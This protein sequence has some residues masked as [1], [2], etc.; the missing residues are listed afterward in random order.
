[1]HAAWAHAGVY[2]PHFTG[3]ETTSGTPTTQG[4]L[5]PGDLVLVPGSRGNVVTPR[6]VGMYIGHG[7]VVHA[8][9]AGDV[10]RVEP[11]RDF[12]AHG[13]VMLRHIR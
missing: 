9:M 5:L 1:V 12:I 2:V 13:L 11:Y 10:V 3:A 4:R 7:L 8:P 6:H